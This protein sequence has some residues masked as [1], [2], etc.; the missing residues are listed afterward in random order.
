MQYL[1]GEPREAWYRH[2]STLEPA[3]LTWRYYV[4]FLANQI[5]DPTN[6]EL[7]NAQRYTDAAQTP[8]QSVH[9]FD[10]Y[11]SGLEAQLSTY[12]DEQKAHHF[13]TRLRSDIKKTIKTYAIIPSSRAG[14][15]ALAARIEGQMGKPGASLAGERQFPHR[16]R[17][18]GN[19]SQRGGSGQTGRAGG[20][21]SQQRSGAVDTPNDRPNN[22]SAG[23][24]TTGSCYNC[25]RAGHWAR[26]CR[27]PPNPNRTPVGATGAMSKNEEA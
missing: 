5:E 24:S 2:E 9:A 12:T 13:L 27:R 8:G 21:S 3:E 18:G 11:L 14:V 19:A 15:V 26:D 7:N 23:S 4:D 6:R 16:M 17:S 10:A 22:A 25:G 1:K 20:D